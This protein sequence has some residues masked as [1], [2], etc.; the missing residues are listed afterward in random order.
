MY[1]HRSCAKA[2]FSLEVMMRARVVARIRCPP[3]STE[4]NWGGARA[5]ISG[6]HRQG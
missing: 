4:A 5:H 3:A 1:M 6:R 2:R